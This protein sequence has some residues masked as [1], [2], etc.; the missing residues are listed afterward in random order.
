MGKSIETESR[1]Q[2]PAAMGRHSLIGG[3]LRWSNGNALELHTVG[4]CTTFE[5]TKGYEIDD[6]K[7]LILCYM[8]LI[9]I[10]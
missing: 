1:L 8:N 4:T 10:F 3:L 6:F 2:Q 9:S 7:C 5:C